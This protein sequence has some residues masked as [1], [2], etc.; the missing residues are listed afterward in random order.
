MRGR[1]AIDPKEKKQLFR[2]FVKAGILDAL[3][4]EKKDELRLKFINQLQEEVIKINSN[5]K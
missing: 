2:V 5:D 3:T 4:D 1:K